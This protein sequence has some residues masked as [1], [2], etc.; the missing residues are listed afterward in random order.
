MKTDLK[1]AFVLPAIAIL[2][3][4]LSYFFDYFVSMREFIFLDWKIV[5]ICLSYPFIW[6]LYRYVFSIYR[7]SFK[8]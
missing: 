7:V 4:I 2:V 1:A 5:T 3:L 8:G 6:A